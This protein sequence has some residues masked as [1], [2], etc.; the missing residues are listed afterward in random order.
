MKLNSVF[1]E[2]LRISAISIKSHM[3]RTVLTILIIAFGIM[4]LVGILTAIESIKSSLNSNFSRMGANT[5]TI[6]NHGMQFGGNNSNRPK[7]N[8]RITYD[9]AEKFKSE[10][11]FNAYTSISTFA[12]HVATVKFKSV[13]TNPNIGVLGADENNIITGGYELDKGRNFTP[14]EV[15]YGANVAIIG[16]TLSKTLFKQK[17][18]P[19]EQVISIGPGKYRVIGVLKEKGSSMGFSGDNNCILPITNVRQYFARPDMSYTI[20]VMT[21]NPNDMEFA[22]SESNGLFRA[23]RKCRIGEESNFAIEKSDNLAKMLVDK[24]KYVTMAAT[25]IGLITLLGAAIGLMNIMLVSVTERTREIGIR[26]AIGATS[27]VIKDQFLTEAIMIC[28]LGGF[29]GIILGILIGNLMS[30]VTGG[31]FIIPWF[32]IISGII[33]CLIVGLASGI[34]PAIKASKLDPIEAL[35]FE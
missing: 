23:I 31:S 2:N 8:R 12:S 9:E 1:L 20:S 11:T 30:L 24:I 26:K 32:W 25:I 18:N 4:A 34:Y 3:L 33:L 19:V 5:F 28:Q 16:G 22:I 27:K 13:K 7:D 35:R 10:F 21:K 29:L 14:S 6:K 17:E 15:I